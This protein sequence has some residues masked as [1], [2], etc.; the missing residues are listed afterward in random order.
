MDF[1]IN[2]EMVHHYCF[3]RQNVTNVFLD[4]AKES[5]EQFSEND[6]AVAADMV[7]KGY[8]IADS[9]ALFVNAPV[10]TKEQYEMLKEIFADTAAE[11]ADNAEALKDTVAKI[12]KNHI[13]VHL[14][15]LFLRDDVGI[16]P[17]TN[18]NDPP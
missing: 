14:K 18:P 6:K 12:I 1:P 16:V 11:I 2:G 10:Y 5:T 15:K 8:V 9:D 13:P 4:I 17:Y 7:R 3:N